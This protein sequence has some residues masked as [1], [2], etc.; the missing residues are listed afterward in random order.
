MKK[1]SVNNSEY[2][3]VP[4]ALSDSSENINGMN[5]KTLDEF[6]QTLEK[7]EKHIENIKISDFFANKGDFE[8]FMLKEIYEQPNGVKET[9]IRRL[10]NN[11]EI[12]LDDIKMTKEDLENIAQKI[13]K[14]K[15]I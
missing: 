1:N 10:N 7:I 9:L 6:N 4:Y 15:P 3:I 12:Q 14:L 11:G 8:H 2:E 5:C 13:N